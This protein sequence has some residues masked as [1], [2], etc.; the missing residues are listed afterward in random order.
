M[1]FETLHGELKPEEK[2][3]LENFHANF[4]SV[5]KLQNCDN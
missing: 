5:K 1:T 2:S 4:L 3:D